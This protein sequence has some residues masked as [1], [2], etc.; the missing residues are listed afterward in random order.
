MVHLGGVGSVHGESAR[1]IGGH[2]P[3]FAGGPCPGFNPAQRPDMR[4]RGG[5]VEAERIRLARLNAPRAFGHTGLVDIA[6]WAF[7]AALFARDC[8]LGFT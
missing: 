1:Q 2:D 8:V 7:W 5:H 6:V 3:G 4:E